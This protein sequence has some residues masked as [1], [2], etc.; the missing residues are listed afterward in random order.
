ML[1]L[2]ACE[3]WTRAQALFNYFRCLYH[4]YLESIEVPQDLCVCLVAYTWNVANSWHLEYVTQAFKSQGWLKSLYILR[5]IFLVTAL[6]KHLLR[7]VYQISALLGLSYAPSLRK[8]ALAR[9]PMFEEQPFK[10]AFWILLHFITSYGSGSLWSGSMLQD[11]PTPSPLALCLLAPF[12]SQKSCLT[13]QPSG[14]MCWLKHLAW[15]LKHLQNLF[16]PVITR[17]QNRQKYSHA[18]LYFSI[19]STLEL[20]QG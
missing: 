14:D 17:N 19:L 20:S 15:S 1:F 6:I 10:G 16:S 4:L 9:F 8:A 11:R 12:L 3:N 2:H 7:D 18:I 13:V 5:G